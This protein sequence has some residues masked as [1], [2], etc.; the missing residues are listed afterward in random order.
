V[1]NAEKLFAH[2]CIFVNQISGREPC[3]N[4]STRRFNQLRPTVTVDSMKIET[5]AVHAGHTID[6]A[7]G[8]VATP[9][10]LSTTF[11]RDVDGAYSRG[12]MYSR[13]SNPN[14]QMLERGVAAIEG[15]AAA[16]AFGSGMAAATA[17]F[18][19]LSPHDHVLAHL[20]AYYGVTR[21]LRDIFER[22]ELEV[23]SI[24]MSDLDAV[25]KALRPN[26]KV[27]W[28][29]TPSN[30]LL[31]IVDLSAIVDIA[32][33]AG[34]ISVC[35]NTWGPIIQRPIDL[36]I[37]I[38]LHSTTKYF[39][40]HCDVLGGILVAREDGEFFQR[41]RSIQYGAGA[42]PSPF[43]C[44]LVLRG[45]HTVPWRMRAHCENAMKIAEHLSKH[46]AIERV[47]YP[48][49]PNHPGHDIARKQM[50]M[51][52][53]MMSI[54]VKGGRE[55]AM[56]AAANTKIFIRATSLGGVESLIE[57]RA[58]IE[59]PGTTSPESLLRLSIGLENADDLIEDL[60]QALAA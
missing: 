46:P 41:V 24:D 4:P 34:A 42:V 54:E 27:I 51:F 45:V 35:D 33:T 59:G 47:H 23:D 53:G 25:K 14:R 26:T 36:G 12:H 3:Q 19:T 22:W 44:W 49:L 16:A 2:D 39:G 52:G 7:T 8:A 31:K 40:G 15:G 57:H 1:K 5:L 17:I 30:P 50:S 29:E 13:N 48:G 6:P 9:I 56:S 60:E 43:D 58:S 11:E 37:D 10:Y 38:V 20:D 18:Q 21:V 55:A 28:T 32:K